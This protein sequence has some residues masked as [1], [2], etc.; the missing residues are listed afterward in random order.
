MYILI[1]KLFN[2]ELLKLYCFKFKSKNKSLNLKNDS[3]RNSIY[4]Y[5]SYLFEILSL[6]VGKMFF[7]NNF[8]NTVKILYI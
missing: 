3:K 1:Q 7:T 5:S 8:L 4:Y 2:R 6:R